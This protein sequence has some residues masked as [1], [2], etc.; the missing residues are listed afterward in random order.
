MRVEL[1]EGDKNFAVLSLVR[2]IDPLFR[3]TVL[4]FLLAVNYLDIIGCP[5]DRCSVA[6]SVQRSG[7]WLPC[8][9]VWCIVQ[10]IRVGGVY[11]DDWC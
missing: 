3:Y 6:E 1:S 4:S 11:E 5:S 8:R 9:H 7:V 2:T 10:R